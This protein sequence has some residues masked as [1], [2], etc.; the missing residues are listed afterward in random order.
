M[1]AY[2]VASSTSRTAIVIAGSKKQAIEIASNDRF[3][4]LP[5]AYEINEYFKDLIEYNEITGETEIWEWCEE[6][7]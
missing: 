5:E 3:M 2:I 6:K 1:K 4:D 7:E